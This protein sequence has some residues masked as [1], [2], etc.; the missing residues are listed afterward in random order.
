MSE[1]IEKIKALEAELEKQRVKAQTAKAAEEIMRAA[2]YLA[3][4]RVILRV[5]VATGGVK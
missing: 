3:D 2:R 4:A 5:Q 1:I